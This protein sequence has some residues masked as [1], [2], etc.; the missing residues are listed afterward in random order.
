MVDYKTKEPSG[1]H[2]RHPEHVLYL[3]LEKGKAMRYGIAWARG[4]THP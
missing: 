3:V 2:R 4:F 1:M